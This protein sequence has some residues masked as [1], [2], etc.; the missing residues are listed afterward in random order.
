MIKK[1]ADFKKES[2]ENMRGGSGAVKFEHVWEP[3]SEMKSNT[4]LFSRLILEK[5]CSV[6]TH[7]HDNEEEVF[8]VLQG[9]AEF[10]ENGVK[11]ILHTGDTSITGGGSSHSIACLGDETCVVLAVIIGF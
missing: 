6:G 7:A 10:T 8:Y 9:T 2:R 5:G 11:T 1:S 4:R 3:C